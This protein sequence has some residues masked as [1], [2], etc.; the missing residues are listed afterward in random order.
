MI[1]ARAHAI[2]D[3]DDEVLLAVDADDQISVLARTERPII[4]GPERSWLLSEDSRLERWG[5]TA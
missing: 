2:E 1:V 3:E 5:M 4:P